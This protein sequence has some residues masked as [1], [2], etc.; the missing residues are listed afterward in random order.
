MYMNMYAEIWPIGTKKQWMSLAFKFLKCF[1]EKADFE[2]D[3][4]ASYTKVLEKVAQSTAPA[5]E[6][7]YSK[8]FVFI[9]FGNRKIRI[10]K[11]TLGL[12]PEEFSDWAE[13]F[14]LFLWVFVY[15][16]SLFF[17][18][19]THL[20]CF[21]VALQP[22]PYRTR[23]ISLFAMELISSATT[24]TTSPP[25]SENFENAENFFR[26]KAEEDQ[27]YTTKSWIENFIEWITDKK[28]GWLQALQSRISDEVWNFIMERLHI[29]KRVMRELIREGYKYV[30]W[31]VEFSCGAS[32]SVVQA[33]GWLPWPLI[34]WSQLAAFKAT[35]NFT[36][37]WRF[38]N[39]LYTEGRKARA[40]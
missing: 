38:E 40:Q 8:R 28:K 13:N 25:A 6:E 20:L 18:L 23:T 31:P 27:F 3:M 29:R 22:T 4:M 33:L 17:C 36:F 39:H 1:E 34:L 9:W 15:P 19:Q 5:V 21:L 30:P 16:I 26:K 35:T 2:A 37:D 24:A 10:S 7:W 11:F 12:F 32:T 14:F